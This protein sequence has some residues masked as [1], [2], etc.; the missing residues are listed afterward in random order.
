[1]VTLKVN[2]NLS[3]SIDFI[4]SRYHPTTLLSAFAMLASASL[5]F[6]PKMLLPGLPL[7]KLSS[8]HAKSLL[9]VHNHIHDFFLVKYLA[10][11]A[12]IQASE[13]TRI[14]SVSHA[15]LPIF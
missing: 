12:G 4:S 15:F 5:N 13:L 8:R 9:A 1:M 6:G 11:G 3:T 14:E 7:S 10:K 2:L